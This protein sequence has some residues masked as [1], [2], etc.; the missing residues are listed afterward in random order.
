VPIVIGYRGIVEDCRR[1]GFDMFDDVVDNSHDDLDDISRWQQAL[2]RNKNLILGDNDL[3][4]LK[5]RLL[6]QREWVLDQWPAKM[7]QDYNKR[8]SEILEN[9]TRP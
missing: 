9:L 2:E 5:P 3:G 8:S 4:H 7:I 1:I 6:Q